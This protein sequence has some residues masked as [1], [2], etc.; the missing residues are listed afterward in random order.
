MNAAIVDTDVVSMF[1]KGDTRALACRSH[2][3]VRSK[4]PTPESPRAPSIIKCP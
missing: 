4:R 1:F 2:K 3:D